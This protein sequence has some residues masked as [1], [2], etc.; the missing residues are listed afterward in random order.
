MLDMGTPV[1]IVD[2]ARRL[3]AS[4]GREMD[5]EFTGLRPGEKLNEDWFGLERPIS[6]RSIH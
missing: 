2:I 5:I 1:R 6:G 3:T 4:T